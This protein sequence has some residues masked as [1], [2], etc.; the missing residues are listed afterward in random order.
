LH[1]P[2]ARTRLSLLLAADMSSLLHTSARAPRH[3]ALIATAWASLLHLGQDGLLSAADAIMHATSDFK[4][5]LQRQ[6]PELRV[7]GSPHMSVVAFA[8]AK[9]KQLNVYC[10][11]DLMTQRGWH[12][13][14]LQAPAALHFCF[15]AQHAAVV[16]SLVADLRSCIDALAANP[17]GVKDGSAPLY[18]LAGVSPDR[19]LVGEF[20]V[21]FQD[22]ML[23]P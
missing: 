9:P 17:A 11:N 7:L 19:G 16:P 22:A 14:A 23:A 4:R 20:L 3:S 1:A 13:N 8:A 12:L 2:V 21:A 6:L 10:L 15:T 5:Q 18:G